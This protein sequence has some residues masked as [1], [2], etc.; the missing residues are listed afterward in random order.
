MA[1]QSTAAQTVNLQIDLVFL[2]FSLFIVA[3]LDD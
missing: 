2:A 3:T 1:E